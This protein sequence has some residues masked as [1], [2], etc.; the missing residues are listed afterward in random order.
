MKQKN[1]SDEF[2]PQVVKE[3][4]TGELGCRLL[5]RKYNIS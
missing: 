4:F 1:Y 3:Y 2:K 5:A